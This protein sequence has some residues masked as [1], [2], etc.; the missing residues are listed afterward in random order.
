[1]K[2]ISQLE[3]AQLFGVNASKAKLHVLNSQYQNLAALGS[4]S[5]FGLPFDNIFSSEKGL[6]LSLSIESIRYFFTCRTIIKTYAI[7]TR[8]N[9]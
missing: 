6:N 9:T 7:G 2:C 8:S 5:G 1:M 4:A 3:L